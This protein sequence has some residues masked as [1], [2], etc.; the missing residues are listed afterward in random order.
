MADYLQCGFFDHRKKSPNG[1]FLQLSAPLVFWHNHQW[2]KTSRHGAGH[3]TEKFS[4][5]TGCRKHGREIILSN[6]YFIL[7]VW[8]GFVVMNWI[9]T[10]LK[11]PPPQGGCR[12]NG[13]DTGGG[14]SAFS[15]SCIKFVGDARCKVLACIC[16]TQHGEWRQDEVGWLP[17]VP[18][19]GTT[20]GR[21]HMQDRR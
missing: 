18:L 16:A 14:C 13:R 2:A 19:Y 10:N 7:S 9:P 12:H 20:A 17:V 8:K 1:Q 6:P 3:F 21:I 15:A 11:R 5:L 4:K